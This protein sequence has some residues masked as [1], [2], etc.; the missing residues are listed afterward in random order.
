M[1]FDILRRAYSGSPA[2]CKRGVWMFSQCKLPIRQYGSFLPLVIRRYKVNGPGALRVSAVKPW[3]MPV[4]NLLPCLRGGPRKSI[5]WWPCVMNE[6][7]CLRRLTAGFLLRFGRECNR[8]ES[9]APPKAVAEAVENAEPVNSRHVTSLSVHCR[10]GEAIRRHKRQDAAHAGCR[11]LSRATAYSWATGI[12][13]S[14]SK[15]DNR[16]NFGISR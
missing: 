11:R 7:L 15:Q 3:L 6:R 12:G 2:G 4:D 1:L 9:N 13:S 10:L 8:Y 14:N 16:K 5:L